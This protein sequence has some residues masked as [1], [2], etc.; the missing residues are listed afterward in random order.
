MLSA[1]GQKAYYI[2]I[3]DILTE[4]NA[5]KRVESFVGIDFKFSPK[6]LPSR[7]KKAETAQI[8]LCTVHFI[9]DGSIREWNAI[10]GDRSC[11]TSIVFCSMRTG[12]GVV[13]GF[14]EHLLLK[15]WA[16]RKF[17]GFRHQMDGE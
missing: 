2:G 17:S 4:Y 9:L 1:D 13:S 5:I 3:I 6:T 12:P 14:S 8:D 16:S 10:M 11:S 7:V 15:F